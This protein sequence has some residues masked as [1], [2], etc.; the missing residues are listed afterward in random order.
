LLFRKD[1]NG[2]RAIAVVAVVI[3]HFN[4]S[5]LPGGFAG[6]DVFFVISGFLMTGI[7]FRGL[8]QD[9]FSILKFYLSRANRIIPPLAVLCSVL[10]LFG[11]FYLIPLDYM[12]LSKHVASSMV[13]LSNFVLYSESGY[14]NSASHEKWLLHTWSLS[15]EWQFYII[16]PLILVALRK[17]LHLNTIKSIVL[18]GTVLGFFICVIASYK[19]PNPSYY[20]LPTRAWEMMVG[21]IAYL[22]PI[23]LDKK[24][25]KAFEY[26][27]LTLI[28]GSY[29]FI[30]SKNLWPGY[31]SAVPVL[32]TFFV[33]QAQNRDSIFTGNVV[34]QSLG[35]W[36]YSIYLWHWPL[37]VLYMANGSDLQFLPIY[38]LLSVVLGIAS[39]LIVE[40]KYKIS[41]GLIAFCSGILCFSLFTYNSGGVNYPFRGVSITEEAQYLS[42]Y[43]K[44]NYLPSLR[45]AYSEKCNFFDIVSEKAKINGISKTCIHNGNGG[46]FIWGDSHAQALSYGIRKTFLNININQIATSSCRP[47]STEDSKTKGELKVACDRANNAAKEVI[48]QLNPQVVLLIQRLEH[49]ENDYS[50]ILSFIKDNNLTSKLVVIGPVPQ[51]E[52]SLPNT[53]V[54]RHFDSKDKVFNDPSFI[55][56]TKTVNHYLKVQYNNSEIKYISIID[57]LCNQSG[58]LTKIDDKNTPLVWDYGHLTRE[59][60]IYVAENI[61]KKELLVYLK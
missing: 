52:P 18:I 23:V 53:I 51:W 24:K 26:L 15:A 44:E 27:G 28:C 35:K 8:E 33:I 4:A 41:T 1:I 12:G 45:H 13:F 49:N 43:Q 25:S 61:I 46:L 29:L 16:Y 50:E 10:L 5:W 7:I 59:G 55:D 34:F 57:K 30:S 58:C 42:R 48:L 36:S 31:L 32:G 9:D 47:L 6:V 60:S 54:K 14:F 40:R 17:I 56:D 19:W 20:L 2:L 21:A 38:V 3:F 11:W 22:Y 37:A 39:Y